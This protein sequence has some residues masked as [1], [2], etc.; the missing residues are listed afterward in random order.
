MFLKYA[1]LILVGKMERG[2]G[3]VGLVDEEGGV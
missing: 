3:W 1:D 2:L